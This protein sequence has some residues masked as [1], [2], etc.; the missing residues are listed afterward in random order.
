VAVIVVTV[1]KTGRNYSSHT[2]AVADI[3]VGL[4]AAD[5]ITLESYNDD[6]TAIAESAFTVPA[7]TGSLTMQPAVGSGALGH[8]N[9]HRTRGAVALNVDPALGVTLEFAGTFAAMMTVNAAQLLT[10]QGL[11]FSTTGSRGR[12]FDITNTN[13]ASRIEDCIIKQSHNLSN[14][15]TVNIL[16]QNNNVWVSASD[17]RD[18]MHVFSREITIKNT[19]FVNTGAQTA[20]IRAV[21]KTGGSQTLTITNSV[22]FGFNNPPLGTGGVL[23]LTNNATD[24]TAAAFGGTG[25]IGSL[26]PSDQLENATFALFDG[27]AK[28]TGALPDAADAASA[29]ATDILGQTRDASPTIGA[30]EFLSAGGAVALAGVLAAVSAV[31]GAAS[32]TRA[33]AAASASV[34]AFSGT[35]ATA[36]QVALAGALA[37][38]SV[39][40]AALSNARALSGQ[41]ISLSTVAGSMTVLRS[42]AGFIGSTS[43][44]VGVFSI[45]RALAAV[46]ASVSA[47]SGTL[48]A[49]GEVAL[50]GIVAA[51]TVLA[52]ALSRAVGASG[53]LAAVSTATGTL[54]R[55]LSLTGQLAAA[56]ALSATLSSAGAVVLAGALAAVSAATGVLSRARVLTGQMSALSSLSADASVARAVSGVVAAVS[57]FAGAMSKT[58]AGAAFPFVRIQSTLR[59]AANIIARLPRV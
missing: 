3:G 22:H 44:V 18:I 47:F 50:A 29:T 4:S 14:V 42:I 38:V 41:L 28:S 11:Q 46:S 20:A 6:G 59:N 26:V 32:V 10:I 43:G 19:T 17:D 57:V 25:T 31:V 13:A 5:D 49:A 34:S 45:A 52:G 7:M 58:V 24:L 1:G 35:L 39:F 37:A 53:T 30:W 15:S 40:S 51:S 27:R 55:L 36:G 9:D 23:V 2:A 8:P 56:S 21:N 33:L 12:P 54:A 48:A 16:T